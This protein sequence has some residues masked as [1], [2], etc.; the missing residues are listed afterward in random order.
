MTESDVEGC[1]CLQDPQPLRPTR[2]LSHCSSP[3]LSLLDALLSKGFT[4]QR[5][6]TEHNN[7]AHMFF[8]ERRASS[9]AAYLQC[10]LFLSDLCKAG[11]LEPPSGQPQAYYSLV[12]HS[13][14]TVPIGLGGKAYRCMLAKSQGDGLGV[15]L[16]LAPA[17]PTRASREFRKRPPPI[18]VDVDLAGDEVP[19][20][21]VVKKEKPAPVAIAADGDLAGDDL[22]VI[23]VPVVFPGSILGAPIQRVPGRKSMSHTYH[24]R[25]RVDCQHDGHAGCGRSRS[26]NLET[27]ALGPLAAVYYL[28]AW[29]ERQ[30][31]SQ[32]GHRGYKPTVAE[33]LDCK[34]RWESP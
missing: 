25:L 9:H 1:I 28:G 3:A 10:V 20:E 6:R 12:L 13:Q 32:A 7:T 21:P 11:Q 15:A 17:P 27:A 34:A 26:I 30:N 24:D 22:E 19:E 5:C 18:V 2:D 14:K 16:S 4:G 23:A 8:D 33:M 29:L 31:G